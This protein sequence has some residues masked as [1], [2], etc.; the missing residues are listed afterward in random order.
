MELK[1]AQWQQANKAY[2]LSHLERMRGILQ[3]VVDGD[4]ASDISMSSSLT[5]A[6]VKDDDMDMSEASSST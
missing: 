3:R 6:G 1:Q 5:P 2:L 4:R